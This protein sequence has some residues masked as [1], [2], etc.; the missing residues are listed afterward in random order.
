MENE[1][2]VLPLETEVVF[3]YDVSIK[4]EMVKSITIQKPTMRNMKDMAKITGSD[5]DREAWLMSCLSGVPV[6]DFDNLH[7]DQYELVQE[8][9]G[10]YTSSTMKST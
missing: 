8:V 2:V 9:L 6:K 4:G 5:L 7:T 3:D 10:K 1:R